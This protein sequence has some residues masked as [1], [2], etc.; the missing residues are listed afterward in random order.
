MMR[1]LFVII[2]SSECMSLQ[3]L[4]PT[5]YLCVL[6]L[7]ENFINEFLDLNPI[8]QMGILATKAKR[9]DRITELSGNKKKHLEVNKHTSSAIFFYQLWNL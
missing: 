9:C 1:H 6:K 7:L 8:S 3:D 4:K 5:R 2:D